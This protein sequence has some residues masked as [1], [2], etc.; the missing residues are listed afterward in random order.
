MSERLLP[1]ELYDQAKEVVDANRKL[2]RGWRSR[3]AAPAGW[4]APL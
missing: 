3:K 1:K 4:C 2:G